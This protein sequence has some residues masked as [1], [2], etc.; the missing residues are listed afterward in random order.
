MHSISSIWQFEYRGQTFYS[1]QQALNAICHKHLVNARKS[2]L[3]KE[4]ITSKYQHDGL[5]KHLLETL[6]QDK[7]FKFRSYPE[8]AR[9]LTDIA[10]D[11]AEKDIL[12]C[13][14]YL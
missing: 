3:L 6:G 14:K 4:V 5:R 10:N 11:Q 9:V 2:V 12:E 13:S 7:K 8:Y 1:V